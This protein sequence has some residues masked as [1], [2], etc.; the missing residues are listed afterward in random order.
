MFISYFHVHRPLTP[1]YMP[2]G[3]RQF[4]FGGTSRYKPIK[5][6]YPDFR[7]LSLFIATFNIGLSTIRQQPL[8]VLPHSHPLD[9]SI[10]HLMRLAT[11]VLG[12][13]Q[14]FQIINSLDI[15]HYSL[16][17][18]DSEILSSLHKS[19]YGLFDSY[20]RPFGI[21]E[22]HRVI[23]IAHKRNTHAEHTTKKIWIPSY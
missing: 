22:Y 11:L 7:K 21:A 9:F 8:R 6:E 12:F 4:L 16:L 13:F 1:P 17:L 18:V 23:A 20:C 3:I 19:A 2:F 15:R 5:I 14:A 10:P